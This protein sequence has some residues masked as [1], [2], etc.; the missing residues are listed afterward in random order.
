MVTKKKK[1]GRVK[2]ENKPMTL[3]QILDLIDTQLAK[4]DDTSRQLWNVL[5][6]LRGPDDANEALK[7]AKTVPIRR[8]AF[9]KSAAI[10]GT[11]GHVNGAFF[12]R[13][14]NKEVDSNTNLF[15]TSHFISHIRN[16]AEALGILKPLTPAETE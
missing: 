10:A 9:P 5:T 3:R 1:P 14:E 2:K 15:Y 7:V 6:A 8:A 4:E 13:P 16:A 12:G 11:Y